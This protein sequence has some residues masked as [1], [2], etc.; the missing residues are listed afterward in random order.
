MAM[1]DSNTRFPHG[2]DFFKWDAPY[3]DT[4]E[5]VVAALYA[6]GIEGKALESIH[7]PGVGTDRQGDRFYT[8]E[9]HAFCLWFQEPL[10]LIF[11]DGTTLEIL[12]SHNGGARIGV[13][14]LPVRVGS[15]VNHTTWNLKS[16][17]S[18]TLFRSRLLWQNAFYVDRAQRTAYHAQPGMAQGYMTEKRTETIIR[19]FLNNSQVLELFTQ[20]RGYSPVQYRLRLLENGEIVQLPDQRWLAAK[21]KNCSVELTPGVG[22]SSDMKIFP[23]YSSPRRETWSSRKNYLANFALSMDV[24]VCSSFFSTVLRKHFDPAIQDREEWYTDEPRFD[25]Y[26]VTRYTMDTAFQMIAEIRETADRLEKDPD[27]PELKPLTEGFRVMDAVDNP[28]YYN[29]IEEEEIR[30]RSIPVAV[31]LYR[32][33]ARSLESMLEAARRDGCD[34]VEFCGP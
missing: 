29:G 14:S 9:K 3:Y 23:V 12:P 2:F 7:V 20:D 13:N 18:L 24:D 6:A 10:Q 21:A 19:I 32:R 11:E 28:E 34:A 30:R 26:G 22:M 15:S 31:D 16:L 8:G 5:R 33:F 4:P 27:D 17:L 1:P 25:W